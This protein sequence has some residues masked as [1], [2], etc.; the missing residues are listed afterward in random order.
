MRKIVRKNEEN[1]DRDKEEKKKKKRVKR[2]DDL[3]WE[4]GTEISVL[5]VKSHAWLEET[6]LIETKSYRIFIGPAGLSK[7]D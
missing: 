5:L 2:R 3:D 6:W 7:A 1:I 4:S